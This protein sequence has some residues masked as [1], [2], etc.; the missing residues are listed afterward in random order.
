MKIDLH[1]HTC[2]SFDCDTAV[3]KLVTAAEDAG[4]DAIAITDH[5]SIS[6]VRLAQKRSDKITI[7]PGMEITT[8]KG[9]HIIGL[10]LKNKIE[11]KDIFEV[12]DDIHAQGGLAVLPHPFRRSSGFMYAKDKHQLYTADEARELL[13]RIDLVE[14]VNLNCTKEAL[15]DADS[16]FACHPDI[17]QSA[18]SDAHTSDAVGKAYIDL[19]DV[20]S[21]SLEDIKEALLKSSRMIRFEAYQADTK[22]R[23]ARDR[24]TSKRKTI[25][26]RA[27]E[28]M[29]KPIGRSIGT[30]FRNSTKKLF[31]LTKKSTIENK[32]NVEKETVV[33][34]GD[35][36]GK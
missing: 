19:E 23:S 24:K 8:W 4:L 11:S 5:D 22:E 20:N 21:N 2:Y 14:T 9:T 15:T 7:I 25:L 10:F 28:Y 34:S 6:A 27:M 1:T 32:K 36:K 26:K 16:F 13:S 33:L 18:G 17:P 31:G 35:K 30:I 3:D 29:Q 12:I